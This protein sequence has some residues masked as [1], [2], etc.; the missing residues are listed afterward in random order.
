MVRKRLPAEEGLPAEQL[1]EGADINGDGVVSEDEFM[2]L[3]DGDMDL[4]GDPEQEVS[5]ELLRLKKK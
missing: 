2:E 1:P 3:M 5:R 4:S